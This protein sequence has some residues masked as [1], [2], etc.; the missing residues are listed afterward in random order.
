ME[1]EHTCRRPAAR[2]VHKRMSQDARIRRAFSSGLQ[3]SLLVEIPW[4]EY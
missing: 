4:N 3:F 1:V 2:D